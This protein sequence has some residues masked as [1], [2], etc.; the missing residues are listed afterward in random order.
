M[1][2]N[3]NDALDWLVLRTKS[4]YGLSDFKAF[5]KSQGDPELQIKCLHIAGT[6]GK[7]S[8]TNYLRS[9]FQYAGYKTGSFTS[10]HL[11]V[12]NDRIRINNEMIPDER[13][14]AY[15]NKYYKVFN[16]YGLSMFEIDMFIACVYF[17]E[18]KV[19][20]AMI[21]VGLGGELDATNVIDPLVSI[22]TTIDYDHMQYLGNTLELI[23]KAKAGII[24]QGRPCVSHARPI[25]AQEV[26]K[27]KC[28][29]THSRLYLVKEPTNLKVTNQLTFDYPDYPEVKLNTLALYQ[30]DNASTVLETMKALKDL[31]LNFKQEDIYEGLFLA[32]WPGRFEQVSAKPLVFLDGAHNREGIEA[33]TKT[34]KALNRP[35]N[36]VFAALKDKQTD[37]M[38]ESLLKITKNVTVTQF[39][40]YRDKPAK[41]LAGNYPV[42]VIPNWEEALK[43][44]LNNDPGMV[45]IT[46]SL[47]FISIVRQWFKEK[48]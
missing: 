37:Q 45:I 35:C 1:F 25:E 28:L 24:K 33:L 32:N 9:I 26:I 4:V 12:H 21:E 3:I 13:L 10:P 5:L 16:E 11:V 31:G 43:E 14:L 34:V 6:N 47:Y 2:N 7:G 15:I 29:E 18:E 46:G 22:I 38:V 23:A 27:N 44:N 36:I 42:K 48:K 19:D 40:F 39:N 17:L 8:T 20:Y 30:A 41:E